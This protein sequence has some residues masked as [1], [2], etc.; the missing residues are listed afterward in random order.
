MELDGGQRSAGDG[1][2]GSGIAA[3]SRSYG[4]AIC[5]IIAAGSRSYG[6][7][8]GTVGAA[9]SRDSNPNRRDKRSAGANHIHEY[10]AIALELRLPNSGDRQ[11]RL[12]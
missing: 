7:S 11:E 12:R 2:V 9:S 10:G 4:D 1:G 8:V 6:L 5:M 3:G